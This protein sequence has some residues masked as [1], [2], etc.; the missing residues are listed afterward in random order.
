MT[1]RLPSVSVVT[2]TRNRH[3]ELLRCIESV[4][5]QDYHG[6]IRH[7]VIGDNSVVLRHLERE[8]KKWHPLVHVHHVDTDSHIP[9]FI[10][11]YVSSRLAYLRNIGSFLF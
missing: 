5:R 11:F 4:E 9:E 7:V 2:V 3:E 10:P 8:L 1:Y 6:P